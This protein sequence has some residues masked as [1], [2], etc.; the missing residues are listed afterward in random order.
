MHLQHIFTLNIFCWGPEVMECLS[1]S[2]GKTY[3]LSIW[4]N[5]IRDYY[6]WKAGVKPNQMKCL[7]TSRTHSCERNWYSLQRYRQHLFAI[8]YFA[9]GS[10]SFIQG[11]STNHLDLTRFTKQRS[12]ANM[13]TCRHVQKLG[14]GCLI[15]LN[16]PSIVPLIFPRLKY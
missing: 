2:T 12:R 15:Q 11:L 16:T 4:F 8:I 10:D 1:I 6:F 5:K 9:F 3:G 14:S 13:N 7:K